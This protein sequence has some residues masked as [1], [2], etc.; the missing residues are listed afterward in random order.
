MFSF[1]EGIFSESFLANQGKEGNSRNFSSADDSRYTVYY[2]IVLL[3]D[4]YIICIVN[5]VISP[6]GLILLLSKYQVLRYFAK[7]FAK[8]RER[9]ASIRE[10]FTNVRECSFA[11]YFVTNFQLRA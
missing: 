10:Q 1:L 5:P 8:L 3:L 9:V 6:S 11:H 2:G 4:D 7:N